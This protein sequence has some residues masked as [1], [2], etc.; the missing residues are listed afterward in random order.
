MAN[1]SPTQHLRDLT[2]VYDCLERHGLVIH[3]GKCVFGV[4]EITFFGHVVN[5]EGIRPMPT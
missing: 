3:L 1:S 4:T 2:P 5:A